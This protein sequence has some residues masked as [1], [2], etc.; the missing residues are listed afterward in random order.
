MYKLAGSDNFL[1]L[2][3]VALDTVGLSGAAVFHISKA[4]TCA[5]NGRYRQE[6]PVPRSV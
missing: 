1:H 5:M 6:L 3:P 2:Q 4:V